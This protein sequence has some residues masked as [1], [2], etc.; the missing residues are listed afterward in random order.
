MEDTLK[1]LVI[2]ASGYDFDE[3][4]KSCRQ[5]LLDGLIENIDMNN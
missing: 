2:F 3:Y 1:N 5:E 4:S